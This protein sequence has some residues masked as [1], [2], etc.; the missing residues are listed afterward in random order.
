[1]SL[2]DQYFTYVKSSESPAIFHRWCFVTAIG[3]LLGRNYWLPFGK[4]RIFPNIYM[5]MIGNPGTRKNTAARFA[6][7]LI[8]DAGYR[9]FSA[10]KTRKEKFLAD[11]AGLT[12]TDLAA[13]NTNGRGKGSKNVVFDELFRGDPT[14]PSELNEEVPEGTEAR[15][16][17]I[18]APEFNTFLPPGDMEFLSDLGELWD[19][20]DIKHFW[21]YRLKNSKQ[22]H[23][24]QPTISLLGGNTHDGFKDMFPAQSL[25]QGILSRIILVHGERSENKIT[26]PEEPSKSLELD[27]V[28][29]LVAMRVAITGAA[30][31]TFQAKNALDLIYRTWRDLEDQR[32]KHYSTRRFTH[33]LKLCLIASATRLSTTIDMPD[34]LLASSLLS[35][36][37]AGMSKALGEFGKSRNSEAANKLMSA[38]YETKKPMKI[39]DLWRVV[40][41]DLEK[42][43]DLSNLLSNLQQADKIQAIKNE[44]F[45][46]K[47]KPI[48]RK[49]LYVDLKLLKEANV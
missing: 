24:Y 16:V 6:K 30:N 13:N 35:F 7:D 5:M 25:G 9:N 19:W 32:F 46:P 36:T 39:T 43:A 23:I 28:K 21:T 15:E 42:L 27:L 18:V 14:D 10:N 40:S 11:L 44:G 38:L 37:E 2:F 33:L 12:E 4:F 49:Q 20:D 47:Q 22:V 8:S 41:S 34:V 29:S 1:M 48:D 31:V 45:L 3:A 26:W 17:F